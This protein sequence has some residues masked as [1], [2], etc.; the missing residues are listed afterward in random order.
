MEQIFFKYKNSIV[1][2]APQK[3]PFPSR[4][5]F[6]NF[7]DCWGILPLENRYTKDE[8][9]FMK[10]NG[11]WT[12]TDSYPSVWK[13]PKYHEDLKFTLW[14]DVERDV[15]QVTVMFSMDE[16]SFT[17]VETM[18]NLISGLQFV[19]VVVKQCYEDKTMFLHFSDEE[20][21]DYWDK[22]ERKPNEKK[23]ALVNNQ[24]AMNTGEGI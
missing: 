18:K 6:I 14:V 11:E 24:V 3:H 13:Y 23:A 20:L 16:D 1:F 19:F 10:N 21:M 22:T 4:Q 12:T 5:A 9:T 7:M 17:S 15:C 2:P 8:E